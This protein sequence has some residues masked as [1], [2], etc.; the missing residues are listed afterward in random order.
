MLPAHLPGDVQ[1]IVPDKVG[2]IALERV[3]YERFVRFGD[4]GI[5][6]TPLVGEVHLHRYRARVQPWGLRV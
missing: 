1:L 4:L 3:E 5:R 2:V 6:E